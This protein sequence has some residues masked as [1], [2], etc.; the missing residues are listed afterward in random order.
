MTTTRK[1]RG[2]ATLFG[3]ALLAGGLVAGPADAKTDAQAGTT[4]TSAACKQAVGAVTAGGAVAGFGVTAGSPPSRSAGGEVPGLY[5]AGAAKLSGSYTTTPMTNGSVGNRGHVVL[6]TSM[7]KSSWTLNADGVLDPASVELYKVGGGWD[8]YTSFVNSALPPSAGRPLGRQ[9]HYG[10]RKDGTLFRW[11]IHYN[12]YWM[13]VK[14][15]A[16]FSS[17]KTMT[18][19]SQ[20]TTYDTL[21]AITHGGALYTIRVPLTS[22]LKP[23][24][25]KVRA[26]TWGAFDQLIATRC[27]QAGTLLLAVDKDLQAGYLYAVGHANG[28]STVIQGL[29]KVTGGAFN[30]PLYFRKASEPGVDL[31]LYGE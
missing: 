15:A 11:D 10:L 12:Q 6:G 26:S 30:A 8:A 20:T 24:V 17:V 9:T 25:K 4:K 22:P 7:Y 29:G 21:L 14:S 3:V 23:V 19:I 28:A 18:L 16:G 27:G 13:Y 1:V 31:P 5:P 2:G